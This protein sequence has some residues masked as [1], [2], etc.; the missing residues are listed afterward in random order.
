MQT[1]AG[2]L[3]PEDFTTEYESTAARRTLMEWY[4]ALFVGT[5][6]ELLFIC[7]LAR[8]CE[9]RFAFAMR[10]DID[11]D[12]LARMCGLAQQELH[13]IWTDAM[14]LMAEKEREYENSS[15]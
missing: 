7:S 9:K 2:R 14:K 4:A 10:E 6:E 5:A 15:C 1:L 12:G 8:A 11:I 3:R 13:E